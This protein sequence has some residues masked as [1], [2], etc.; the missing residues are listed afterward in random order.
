MGAV[1]GRGSLLQNDDSVKVPRST[2]TKP[3]LGE[4]SLQ[5][6]YEGGGLGARS[7]TAGDAPSPTG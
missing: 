1:S 5:N 4:P 6:E 2:S 7:A 3:A